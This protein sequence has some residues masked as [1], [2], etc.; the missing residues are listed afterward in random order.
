MMLHPFASH[1]AGTVSQTSAL[2]IFENGQEMLVLV[3]VNHIQRREM[4]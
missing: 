2:S 1:A 4:M 3:T